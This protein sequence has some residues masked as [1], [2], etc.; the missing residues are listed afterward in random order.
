MKTIKPIKNI[1]LY[2]YV[3]APEKESPICSPSLRGVYHTDGFA[4]ASDAFI[5]VADKSLYDERF[6]NQ[7]IDK[8]RVVISKAYPNWK[9]TL[10]K[11]TKSASCDFLRLKEYLDD[12]KTKQF[13]FWKEQKE[14]Y[15]KQ[16]KCSQ[17]NFLNKTIINLRINDVLLSIN[18]H[19]LSR[20]VDYCLYIGAEQIKHGDGRQPL[21]AWND[22][23]CVLAMPRNLAT[24]DKVFFNYTI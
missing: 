5:L 24:F 19:N 23:G 21:Y 15:G 3:Y 8:N 6:E 9:G 17:K 2:K 20:F 14:T 10:P 7:I 4:V 18:Y 22:K 12:I 13:T 1:D 16:Y 11:Y